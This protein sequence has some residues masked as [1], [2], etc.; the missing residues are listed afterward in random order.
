MSRSRLMGTKF[1]FYKMK[2]FWRRTTVTA[3]RLCECTKHYGTD[4]L[5]MIKMVNFMLCVFDN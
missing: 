3:A 2:T 5:K 1:Q 4:H